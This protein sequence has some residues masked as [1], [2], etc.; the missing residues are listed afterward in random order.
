[1]K[2]SHH[3][4]FVKEFWFL[5]LQMTYSTPR[6]GVRG[7]WWVHSIARPWVSISSH[8]TVYSGEVEAKR[9]GPICCRK[10]SSYTFRPQGKPTNVGLK[11]PMCWA[12]FY[13]ANFNANPLNSL[14]HLQLLLLHY[15][16]QFKVLLHLLPS[17]C[18]L[19]RGFWDPQFWWL[20]RWDLYQSKTHPRLPNTFQ[21]KVLLDLPR[22]G[23]N[24][25]VRLWP[26]PIRLLVW[27]LGWI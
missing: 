9:H 12:N 26:T 21:Y 22:F 16:C 27:G 3:M 17:G 7:R 24:S 13:P 19:K 8:M 4:Y 20:G 14:V 25:I 10:N 1:M 2:K 5:K 6:F 11:P 15:A 23:R 18:N